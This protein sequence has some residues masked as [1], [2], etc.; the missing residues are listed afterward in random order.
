MH[1]RK[2]H[3]I[4][5]SSASC[6][7][8]IT[9]ISP[10]LH[11]SVDRPLGSQVPPRCCY[12]SSYRRAWTP[13]HTNTNINLPPYD[14][15]SERR[16][17]QPSNTP[18]GRIGSGFLPSCLVV[19]SGVETGQEGRLG[20]GRT[21]YLVLYAE[22]KHFTCTFVSKHHR[23]SPMYTRCLERILRRVPPNGEEIR[24]HSDDLPVIPSAPMTCAWSA[25]NTIRAV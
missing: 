10:T 15:H 4:A 9:M 21:R 19:L 1:D 3:P 22:S 13:S 11:G 20:C 24:R 18:L 8:L 12:S 25:P 6:G 16:E 7:V 17:L 14:T 5:V 2:L 23:V